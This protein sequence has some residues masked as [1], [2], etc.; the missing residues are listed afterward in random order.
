MDAN[1]L[2]YI[3][4]VAAQLMP[5][6]CT[7]FDVHV[8]DADPCYVVL[9]LGNG[10]QDGGWRCSRLLDPADL[11]GRYPHLAVETA[12]RDILRQLQ[13]GPCGA[14]QCRRTASVEVTHG[15]GRVQSLCAEHLGQPP[16]SSLVRKLP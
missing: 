7:L 14:S 2:R 13:R 6:D 11:A 15:D 16:G 10:S 12:V 8:Q 5:E 4:T 3:I 9:T 1:D